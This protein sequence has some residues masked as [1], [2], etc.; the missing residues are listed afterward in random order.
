MNHNCSALVIHRYQNRPIGTFDPKSQQLRHSKNASFWSQKSKQ[1]WSWTFLGTSRRLDVRMEIRQISWF[2]SR[3]EHSSIKI[4][5]TWIINFIPLFRFHL[6]YKAE[7]GLKFVERILSGL[8]YDNMSDDVSSENFVVDGIWN[9]SNYSR[10]Q[11]MNL[12]RMAKKKQVVPVT[13]D[14]RRQGNVEG[15]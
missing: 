5:C 14:L 3:H 7:D 12:R 6:V 2:L 11:L 1:C 4:D 8:P 13:T 10:T 15:T 9:E